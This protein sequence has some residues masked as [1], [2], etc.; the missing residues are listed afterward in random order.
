MYI[1]QF[2]DGT[3]KDDWLITASFSI[4]DL[5]KTLLHV[6]EEKNL[7]DTIPKQFQNCPLPAPHAAPPAPSGNNT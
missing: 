6:G 1:R 2:S 5:N 3:L 4:I 7:I